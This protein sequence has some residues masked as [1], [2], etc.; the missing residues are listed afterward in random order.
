MH[1][2]RRGMDSETA[3]VIAIIVVFIVIGIFVFFYACCVT[4]EKLKMATKKKAEEK[5]AADQKKATAASAAAPVAAS[6][7]TQ[8]KL[9]DTQALGGKDVPKV[10]VTVSDATT[11]NQE[12]LSAS[13][14]ASAIVSAISSKCRSVLH[15]ADEK[16]NVVIEVKPGK[17]AEASPKLCEDAYSIHL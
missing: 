2:A 11:A 10:V 7:A 17:P 14:L 16:G 4:E 13:S 15:P 6:P 3:F 1:P 12:P 5:K 8:A 9:G